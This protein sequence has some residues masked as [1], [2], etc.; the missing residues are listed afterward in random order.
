MSVVAY[1]MLT[2]RREAS[3]PAAPGSLFKAESATGE[4]PPPVGQA[5]IDTLAALV[6]AEVLAAH[7][8][9]LQVTTETSGDGTVITEPGVLTFAFWALTVAALLLYLLVKF[10]A[11]TRLDYV[12]MLIPPLAFVGWT[13]LQ[14]ASAFDAAFDVDWALRVTITVVAALLLAALARSLAYTADETPG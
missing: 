4:E 10:P 8:V 13:M 5:T 1:G 3:R 6:P 9:I 14:P 2:R 7:A 12:R 11:W